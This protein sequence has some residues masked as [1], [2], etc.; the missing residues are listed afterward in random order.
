MPDLTPAQA[1]AL[2]RMEPVLGA[3]VD[4]LKKERI[5]TDELIERRIAEVLDQNRL[6]AGLPVELA[7]VQLDAVTQRAQNLVLRRSKVIK[8]SAHALPLALREAL[9]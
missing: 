9:A 8:G 3:V 5:R 7:T 6:L 4:I 1:A 2:K